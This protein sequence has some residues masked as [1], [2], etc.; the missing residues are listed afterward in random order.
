MYQHQQQQNEHA[1]TNTFALKNDLKQ[2]ACQ[3]SLFHRPDGCQQASGGQQPISKTA[4]C[5]QKVNDEQF[6]D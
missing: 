3:D 5:T 1:N 2:H 4:D 6:S